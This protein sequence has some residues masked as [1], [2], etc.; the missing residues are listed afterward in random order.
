MRTDICAS[1]DYDAR[2][3]LLAALAEVGGAS[4]GDR[5]SALGVGLNRFTV[6]PEAL[7]VFVDAW[8]VDLEGPDELVRQVLQLISTRDH[9]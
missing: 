4:E 2:E 6:G 8:T 5:E 7:T 9:G 1:D 3:R